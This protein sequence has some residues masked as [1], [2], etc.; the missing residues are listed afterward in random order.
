MKRRK[1]GYRE[2]MGNRKKG[3]V[4][5]DASI[6]IFADTYLYEK[7]CHKKIKIIR[8]RIINLIVLKSFKNR[9]NRMCQETHKC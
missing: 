1:R 9:P 2:N 6:V 4:F 8:F 7:I 3:T 5:S